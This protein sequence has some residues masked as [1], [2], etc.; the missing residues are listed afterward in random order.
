MG[1]AKTSRFGGKTVPSGKAEIS[2]VKH[3]GSSSASQVREV[4]LWIR[5][6][7]KKR[8]RRVRIAR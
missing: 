7:K 4:T 1:C 6:K 3:E 2:K 5:K 8:P